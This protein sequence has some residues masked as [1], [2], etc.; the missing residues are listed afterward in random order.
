MHHVL[1]PGPENL[2]GTFS[3]DLAPVLTVAS[4]DTVE[5]SVPD[6]WWGR[7]PF[8]DEFAPRPTLDHPHA[9]AGHALVGPIA[10]RGVAAGDVLRIDVLE[11]TPG[12]Y[13]FTEA[14]GYDWA[15]L[16]RLGCDAPPPRQLLWDIDLA[17]RA[18]VSRNL[19]RPVRVPL[20]PFLGVMG[21]APPSPGAH[22]TVPP[23][24]V[25][26]NLDCKLL[27]AGASLYLPVHVAGGLLSV[28]DGHAAQGDGELS[29]NGIECAMPRVVLAL[30]RVD[31]SDLAHTVARADTHEGLAGGPLVGGPVVRFVSPRPGWAVLG[32]GPTLD[33]AMTHAARRTLVLLCAALGCSRNEALGLLSVAV[34]FRITQV[35][36]RTVG[37]HAVVDEALLK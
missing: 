19:P 27:T 14:G 37:V 24:A 17:G 34:D 22:S 7:T 9:R 1:P 33:D 26:G 6:A 21:L 32:L 2:V 30:H 23:R 36:N 18:A 4:G 15:H 12:T 3:P 11:L 28:G 5:L 10:V 25:G 16:A 29:N 31:P 8:A 20:A 35:V 13:G